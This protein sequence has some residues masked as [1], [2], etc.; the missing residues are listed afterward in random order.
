[1]GGTAR[2]GYGNNHG[3]WH[4]AGS[5]DANGVLFDIRNGNAT[6][7]SY[8]MKYNN[9]TSVIT[10][11]DVTV[12]SIFE[13]QTE[14]ITM[15]LETCDGTPLDDGHVR[16]GHGANFGTY[17]FVG[18]D[19]GSSATGE[20]NAEFFPGTYSFEMG[21]NGTTNVKSSYNFPADGATIVWQTI[22]V[23]LQ[24]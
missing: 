14:L 16:W 4:V 18:G 12:N 24:Y 7:M 5:T 17:H 13:F 21:Y 23:T 3:T 11:Q 9:T 10:G 20:T 2:G 15:R 6:T 1:S 19:T 8:E 22:S